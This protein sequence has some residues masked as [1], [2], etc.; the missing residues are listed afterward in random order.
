MRISLLL[1]IMFATAVGYGQQTPFERSG[2]T[3]TATYPECIRFYRNLA[4]H[5]KKIRLQEMGTSDAGYPMHVV[6]YS[7]EGS[8]DPAGWHAQHKIVILINNG[9][10]PGEPDGVD[11]S[12]MLLR[13]VCNGKI[14]VPSNIALAVIPLYNIGGALN[15]NSCSRVN[16]NGPRSFGFRGN[17]QNLDLNRDFTKSDSRNAR[18][19]ARIF[20][21]VQPDI[22]VDNHVSDGADYQH[23]MTL[24]STQWNKL[25]GELG[26][27]VHDTFDPSLFQ[28]MEKK[29]W[30]MCPYVN[31]E[32]GSPEKGWQEFYD[33]PRYSSGYAALFHCISYMPETHMLK[34]FHDRVLS[35]YALLQTIME[36]ASLHAGQIIEKRKLQ[37]SAELTQSSLAIHWK[38]DTARYDNILFKGYVAAQKT[39]E[40][41]GLQ[42][43][44]YDH[45]KPFDKEV[46]YFDY[47]KG[48]QF[49]KVPAYYVLPQGWHDVSELLLLNGV[50]LI[51]LDRDTVM[52]VE[53]Y[54]IDEYKSAAGAYEK[55]HR[56]YGVK[57][58]ASRQ[59]IQ[60]L[61]GD[62]LIPCNQPNRRFI[63]EMLEPAGED[64]YFSWNFFDAILQQKEGYSEYRWEDVAATYLRDHP[65]LKKRLEEKKKADITFAQN[66]S[67]QLDFIYKNSPYYEPAHLRFP[68]YRIP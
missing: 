59:T 66:A 14:K 53:A 60:F 20:H 8:F 9:I 1:C 47:F 45:D 35:T 31:F 13:D 22:Q 52:E 11:A 21:W 64:S 4:T 24:I 34:P 44:Y 65:E 25:G 56:N 32:E 26:Q 17:A 62:Y 5:S 33:P 57:V 51:A 7:S 29:G 39:S 36:Q 58:S 42:R 16:Q 50:T 37:L 61:Q 10:H 18:A 12:M 2:G 41:T 43:L 48:D 15:R 28:A 6:L 19:F 3:E 46:R 40:V 38:V 68:V 23:T 27:F 54:H 55:H 49:V 63:A 30:P 67:A